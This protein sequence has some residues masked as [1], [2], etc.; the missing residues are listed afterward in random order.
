MIVHSN[1]I[2][3]QQG[4]AEV[5]LEYEDVL[6]ISNALNEATSAIPDWEYHMRTGVEREDAIRLHGEIKKLLKNR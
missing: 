6:S 5:T 4:S 3:D 1:D 2:S